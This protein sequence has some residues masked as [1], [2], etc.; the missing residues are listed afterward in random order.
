M[1]F[2]SLADCN[3]SKNDQNG[4]FRFNFLGSGRWL[5]NKIYEQVRC[6][7]EKL[8]IMLN[9]DLLMLMATKA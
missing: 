5:E 9:F 4:L 1:E 7:F 6:Y 2:F 3:K 8:K